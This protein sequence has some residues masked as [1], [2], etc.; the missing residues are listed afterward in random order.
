MAFGYLPQKLL[1]VEEKIK[2][3][4]LVKEAENREDESQMDLYSLIMEIVSWRAENIKPN[5]FSMTFD[6]V[7]KVIAYI[8]SNKFDVDLDN[9]MMVYEYRKNDKVARL[10]FDE[11]QKAY[12]N[13]DCNKYVEKL[14]I[15][16]DEFRKCLEKMQLNQSEIKSIFSGDSIPIK[17]GEIIIS[18]KIQEFSMVDKI[19]GFGIDPLKTLGRDIYKYFYTYCDAQDYLILSSSMIISVIVEYDIKFLRLFLS[20]F[21]KRL[22][23][24]ELKKY[25]ELLI[26]L[27]KVI[28]IK[29]SKLYEVFFESIKDKTKTSYDEWVTEYTIRINFGENDERTLFW[30]QFRYSEIPS[31]YKRSDALVFKTKQFCFIEF[32]GEQ[33]GPIY[34]FD[35]EYFE[36]KAERLFSRETSNTLRLDILKPMAIKVLKINQYQFPNDNWKKDW[37]VGEVLEGAPGMLGRKNHTAN[38]MRD[39]QMILMRRYGIKKW[40]D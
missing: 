4:H 25:D 6:K 35:R 30:K 40:E 16:D 39:M 14:F 11:W 19:N 9:L 13:A 34:W 20:N 8:P 23:I 37:L 38:W 22:S 27:M 10:L 36:G 29:G 31:K 33:L 21:L 5:I 32:V 26:Y 28:G 1:D 12:N 2:K 3:I 15:E 7:K 24:S 18:R 17:F